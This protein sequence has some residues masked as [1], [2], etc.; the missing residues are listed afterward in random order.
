[1]TGTVTIIEEEMTHLKKVRWAWISTAGGAA[2]LATTRP[3]SGVI[4]RLVTIPD[5]VDAPTTLYDITVTDEDGADILMGAGANRSA[6]VTEQVLASSLGCVANDL[7]TLNISA[8][9]NAKKGVV[10]LYI[11]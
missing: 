8:A 11:R 1:M 4:E 3:F 5:A 2:S 10:V 6:T 9:G 7:L